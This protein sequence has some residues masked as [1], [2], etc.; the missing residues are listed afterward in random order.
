MGGATERSSFEIQEYIHVKSVYFLR[1]Y[2]RKY[3]ERITCTGIGQKQPIKPSSIHCSLKL[4][5]YIIT[6]HKY[7]IDNFGTLT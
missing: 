5:T 7:T 4:K 1:P 2:Y 6:R 3:K